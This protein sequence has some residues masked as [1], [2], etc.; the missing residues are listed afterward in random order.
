MPAA[1]TVWSGMLGLQ[2]ARFDLLEVWDPLTSVYINVAEALNQLAPLEDQIAADDARIQALEDKTESLDERK[3]D[4][5]VAIAPLS[6]DEGV[7]P[8]ELSQEEGPA[9]ASATAIRLNG[10]DAYI[11]FSEGRTDVL[12]FTKDWSLGVTVVTQ[13]SSVQGANL[14]CFASGGVSLNLKVQGEPSQTSNWGSYNTSNGDLYHVTARFNTN[15]WAGPT[16]ASRLLWIYTASTKKL[17]YYISCEEG[18]YSRKANIAV[19]Q[20]AIDAQ[21]PGTALCFSKPWTGTGGASFF[22]EPRTRACWLIG[23]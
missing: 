5:F 14:A 8:N 17:A 20:S 9:P 23:C 3:A 10:V 6:L 11:E 12:D 16:D 19:P 18:S 2:T 1:G 21:T 4:K 22:R 13:G 7:F 15:T